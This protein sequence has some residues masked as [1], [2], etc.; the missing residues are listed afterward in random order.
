[1]PKDASKNVDRYKVRGGTLN[2][3]DFAHNQ[4]QVA[5]KRAT[6]GA[7]KTKSGKSA[8]AAQGKAT[9]KRAGKSKKK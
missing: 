3:F 4:E 1:M 2:E 5:E 9:A 6:S 7:K 8:K